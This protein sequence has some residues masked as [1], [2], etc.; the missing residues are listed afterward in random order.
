MSK[1]TEKERAL[2]LVGFIVGYE[3]GHNDT[4]EGWYGCA[5]EIAADWLADA[6]DDGGLDYHLME[7]GVSDE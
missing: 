7:R 5:E 2:V 1:L 3:S 4:V 6:I